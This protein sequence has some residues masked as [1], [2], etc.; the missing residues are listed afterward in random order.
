MIHH[1]PCSGALAVVIAAA[2]CVGIPDFAQSN[3]NSFDK[4][5]RIIT[6]GRIGFSYFDDDERLWCARNLTDENTII[7][8]L[9]KMS[10]FR[11]DPTASPRVNGA[12]SGMYDDSNALIV[13]ALLHHLGA[14]RKAFDILARGDICYAPRVYDLVVCYCE[15]YVGSIEDKPLLYRMTSKCRNWQNLRP[16]GRGYIAEYELQK[17]LYERIIP[18]RLASLVSDVADVKEFFASNTSISDADKRK[19]LGMVKD[20]RSL[21]PLVKDDL[22]GNLVVDTITDQRLLSEIAR[23]ESLDEEK[24]LA[25]V[26]RIDDVVLLSEICMSERECPWW[27]FRSPRVG[28]W[29]LARIGDEEL[30]LRIALFAKNDAISSEA[31]RLSA[32]GKKIADR[33][34]AFLARKELPESRAIYHVEKFDEGEATPGLYRGVS[35]RL[36]RLVFKKL[37]PNDRRTVREEESGICDRIVANARTRA[38]VSFEIGGFSIGMSADDVF[39]LI[40][41]Y[42]PDIVVTEKE[43]EGEISFLLSCQDREF[44]RFGSDGKAC[45]FNF[46]KSILGKICRYDVQDEREWAMTF[47]R[48]RG[49]DMRYVPVEKDATVV[50]VDAG[51]GFW[52]KLTVNPIYNKAHLRQDAWQYKDNVRGCTIRYFGIPVV[53]RSDNSGLIEAIAPELLQKRLHAS[54]RDISFPCGTLQ[55]RANDE[56]MRR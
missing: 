4:A 8:T 13:D 3:E 36:K 20:Q 6:E 31:K 17:T 42:Y 19:A 37:S 14:S 33:L 26:N 48:E 23:D 24:R 16:Q 51:L 55:V 35:G 38:K 25:A 50:D 40:G 22:I 32:G 29:A 41:R 46:D 12:L 21:V 28:K 27:T 39:T 44:C 47:S 10:H 9:E 30:L 49:F 53:K 1:P 15:S 2:G 7:E 54:F 45:L 43:D 56:R 34:L 52:G 11:R 5:S 18:N